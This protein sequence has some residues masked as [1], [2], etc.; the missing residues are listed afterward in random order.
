MATYSA[1][2]LADAGGLVWSVSGVDAARFSVDEPG[3]A[4]RFSIEATGDDLFLQLPDFD[5]PHD[6]D[7]D[8]TYEVTVNVE[9]GGDQQS[10]DVEVTV[11]DEPEPGRLVLSSTRPG[12]GET[13]TT[14]LTDSDGVMGTVTYEWERSVGRGTWVAL[15]DTAA[16]HVTTAADT[17][18]FLRVTATYEDGHGAANTATAR[19]S[20]VVTADLL[21]G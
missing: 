1:S 16:S 2:S 14:T 12:L 3:G 17:G 20:E 11:I 4:L 18:R 5:D 10:L 19:S 21:T 13:L 9:A 6:D 7:S 15:A 8:G